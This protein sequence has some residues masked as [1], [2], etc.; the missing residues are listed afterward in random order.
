M[1]QFISVPYFKLNNIPQFV[2]QHLDQLNEKGLLTWHSGLDESTILIKIGADHGK[3]LLKFTL[4]IAN[5]FAPN[6]Q[7]NTIVIGIA[8]IKDTY[9]NL[10]NFLEGGLLDDLKQLQNHIW[11]GKT[12]KITLN[13]DYDFLCKA[14]GLSGPV[15]TYPCLWCL[16]PKNE[17]NDPKL[18][19]MHD[20]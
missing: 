10:H 14:Y 11:N 4:E 5:T 16:F 9:Q 12:I 2:D 19:M 7:E 13:G 17:I 6:S 1:S 3:N 20:H 8:A 18:L 15:G